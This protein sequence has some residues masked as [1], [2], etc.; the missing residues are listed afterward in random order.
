MLFF[1][2][3]SVDVLFVS[4]HED[5]EVSDHEDEDAGFLSYLLCDVDPTPE[6]NQ[7]ASQWP[8]FTTDRPTQ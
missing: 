6:H 7:P 4:G 5:G 3:T 8:S 1:E 2:D